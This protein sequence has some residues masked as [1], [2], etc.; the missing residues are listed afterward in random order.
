VTQRPDLRFA[1]IHLSAPIALGGV[2]VA[3][4]YVAGGENP[5]GLTL[6]RNKDGRGYSQFF[7]GH[8]VTK[9][10]FTGNP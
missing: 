1:T 9:I 5:V 7:P 2:D 4:G 3:T 10:E 6:F 8:L